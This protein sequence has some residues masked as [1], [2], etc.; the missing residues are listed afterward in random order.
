M[1]LTRQP[2]LTLDFL[3]GL[4]IVE[5]VK[6]RERHHYRSICTVL[7]P[8]QNHPFPLTEVLADIFDLLTVLFVCNAGLYNTYTLSRLQKWNYH[9]RNTKHKSHWHQ[10]YRKLSFAAVLFEPWRAQSSQFFGSSSSDVLCSKRRR[11]GHNTF[12]L[13][14]WHDISNNELSQSWVF[15]F[16]NFDGRNHGTPRHG[17]SNAL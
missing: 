8:Y 12:L 10:L 16:V 17:H 7:V 5:L 9:R 4:N 15:C 2:C 1:K 13:H 11:P 3:Y 14:C 6:L